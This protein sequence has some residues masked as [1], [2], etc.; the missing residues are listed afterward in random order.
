MFA[1]AA[2]WIFERDRAEDLVCRLLAA[3]EAQDACATPGS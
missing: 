1:S 3:A 2:Y